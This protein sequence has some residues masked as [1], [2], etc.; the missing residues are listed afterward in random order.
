MN[1]IRWFILTIL[2]LAAANVGTRWWKGRGLITIHCEDWPASKVVREIEKQSGVTIK[3]NLTDETKVRMH[4]DKVPLTEALETFA[5]VADGR[6]RLTYVFGSGMGEIQNGINGM[7][8][9][10]RPEGWKRLYFPMRMMGE[11]ETGPEPDPRIDVWQVKAPEKNDFQSYAQQA[12]NSV[13]AAFVFPETWNPTVTKQPASG[14]IK[15]SAPALAKA[16]NGRVME[17]FLVQKNDR[18][19]GPRTAGDDRDRER[20]S[21]RFG[22][23]RGE[24]NN[25][26]EAERERRR[27]M[28]AER[29]QAEIDKLP[30]DK[31]AAAQERFAERRKFFEGLRDL[32][33]AERRAKIEEFMS[34][35]A[36]Q[37]RMEARESERNARM[38]PDQ[39]VDRSR[40]YVERKQSAMKGTSSR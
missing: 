7:L 21:G 35:P 19:D 5:V 1:R 28:M 13:S 24:G 23:N 9:G 4:L 36:N 3:T 39:R 30:A 34:S 20:G 10:E 22:F 29:L 33:E 6:W 16:S 38:T 12:A 32:P 25:D 37:E 11:E 15:K 26:D 31:R 40:S 14:P 18:D 8:A 2:V 27:R 17:V